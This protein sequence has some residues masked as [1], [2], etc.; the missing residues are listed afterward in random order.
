M[1]EFVL[2][3]RLAQLTAAVVFCQALIPAGFMP[4]QGQLAVLCP[5]GLA[6]G[7][8]A[9]LSRTMDHHH[10]HHHHHHMA[11]GSS[12][13]HHDDATTATALDCEYA[14][15]LTLLAL[16]ALALLIFWLAESMA[17]VGRLTPPDNPRYYPN[18]LSRAPPCLL[19][20]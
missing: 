6:P 16:L 18:Y 12:A 4:G 14:F 17:P 9:A 19:I 13:H 2:R 20:A 1:T 5:D 3:R 11:H 8:Y 7:V 10:H 15:G